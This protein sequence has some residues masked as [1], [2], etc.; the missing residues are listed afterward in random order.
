M[1]AAEATVSRRDQPGAPPCPGQ[2]PRSPPYLPLLALRVLEHAEEGDGVVELPEL[3]ERRALGEFLLYPVLMLLQL[4]P[5]GSNPAQPLCEARAPHRG[6]LPLPCS[7]W[8]PAAGRKPQTSLL[9]LA[10]GLKD[11]TRE[12]LDLQQQELRKG[13]G[14]V[15][16]PSAKFAHCL[17]TW[18]NYEQSPRSSL[19]R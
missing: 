14:R 15:I 1:G 12:E 13:L 8:S 11:L 17:S 18:Q 16:G 9:L 10:T 6:Q 19:S 4:L 7:S 2:L 5:P 3:Q